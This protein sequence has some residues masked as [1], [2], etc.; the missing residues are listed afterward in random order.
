MAQLVVVALP[1]SLASVVFDVGN[2]T[3]MV[4]VASKAEF[5]RRN[6]FTSGTL[7]HPSFSVTQMAGIRLV[8]W[9]AGG[10]GCVCVSSSRGQQGG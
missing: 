10:E 3:F 2:S 7:G 5:T 8:C 1:V 4:S 6:S 9:R